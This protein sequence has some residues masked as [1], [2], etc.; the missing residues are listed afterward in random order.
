M[1]SKLLI[2]SACLF[3][4]SS[5]VAQADLIYEFGQSEYH[6]APNSTID[7][8][9]FLTQ[10]GITDVLTTEGLDSIGGRVYFN[11]PPVPTDPAVVLATIDIITSTAF[12]DDLF[13]NKDLVAGVSAGVE[14]SIDFNAGTGAVKGSR[15]LVGTFRFTAGSVLGEVTNLRGTDFDLTPG[16]DSIVSFDT[17]T[18]LDS[19]LGPDARAT[20]TVSAVPEPSGFPLLFSVLAFAC[21][22]RRR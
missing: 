21:Q 10:T 20:I 8:D 12:D 15:I 11:D 19:L 4:S 9:L 2:L 13:E 17:L 18:G 7:V 5:T 1:N 16:R 14:D 3:L 22:R 6:V